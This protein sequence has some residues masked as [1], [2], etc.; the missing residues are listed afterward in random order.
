MKACKN[1]RPFWDT[2]VLAAYQQQHMPNARVLY[3]GTNT[4]VGLFTDDR[5][6]ARLLRTAVLR[7][8][9]HLPPLKQAIRHKLMSEQHP[10]L[11][12]F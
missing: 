1:Q 11:R 6:P 9:N 10:R 3:H 12:V 4:V 5:L 7:I 2:Q 8:S